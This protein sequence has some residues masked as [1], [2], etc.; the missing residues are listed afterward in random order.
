[1][2]IEA[3]L[4]KQQAEENDRA[5]NIVVNAVHMRRRLGD[6]GVVRQITQDAMEYKVSP[7]TLIQAIERAEIDPLTRK[8]LKSKLSSKL[9]AWIRARRATGAAESV[10]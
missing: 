7:E 2:R 6:D 10:R 9:D 1:L 4:A 5:H 8:V 3:V